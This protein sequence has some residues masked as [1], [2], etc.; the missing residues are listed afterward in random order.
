[1][2]KSFRIIEYKEFN[3]PTQYRVLKEWTCKIWFLR[4]FFSFEIFVDKSGE[5]TLLCKEAYVTTNNVNIQMFVEWLIE[6][7]K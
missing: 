1:M 6:N 5:T 3:E 4:P 2:K 7:K